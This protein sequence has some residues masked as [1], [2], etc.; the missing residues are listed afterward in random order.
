M[1]PASL[2]HALWDMHS[3]DVSGVIGTTITFPALENIHALCVCAVS[4]LLL[5]MYTQ[6]QMAFTY[7]FGLMET[8]SAKV[9]FCQG[10]NVTITSA[11]EAMYSPMSVG[12]L[13]GWLVSRITQKASHQGSR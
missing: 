4:S 5:H 8:G 3:Q 12:W 11:K 13:V 10:T 1:L 6:P 7:P 9:T 2:R